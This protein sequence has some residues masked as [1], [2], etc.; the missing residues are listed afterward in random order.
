MG[1]SRR[2]KKR[3]PLHLGMRGRAS[4][5][6]AGMQEILHELQLQ[7]EIYCNRQGAYVPLW[8]LWNCKVTCSHQPS[9][10]GFRAQ[11]Q[12]AIIGIS[13]SRWWGFEFPKGCLVFC[14]MYQLHECRA[15]QSWCL[16]HEILI[17]F[18]F[19]ASSNPASAHHYFCLLWIHLPV[20]AH[21]ARW[22]FVLV[23]QLNARLSLALFGCVRF[24]ATRHFHNFTLVTLCD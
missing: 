18:W 21:T 10:K 7:G 12:I 9:L 24:H 8:R 16:S 23:P 20:H 6:G 3:T 22:L 13:I 14:W 2:T 5:L 19:L 4:I 1:G 15:R 17:W 11:Y